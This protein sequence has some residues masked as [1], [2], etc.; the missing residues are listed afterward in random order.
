MPLEIVTTSLVLLL[1]SSW[2]WLKRIGMFAGSGIGACA[3]SDTVR[4]LFR[5]SLVRDSVRV[6]G[7]TVWYGWCCGL[8]R[9]V[10]RCVCRV[11][12]VTVWYGTMACCCCYCGCGDRCRLSSL[13]RSIRCTTRSV[14]ITR[15]VPVLL[16]FF[17]LLNY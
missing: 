17:F 10:D 2:V 16:S 9:Y 6:R 3:K 5:S 15:P 13:W 7:G 14:S 12:S 11:R 8:R 4:L 1:S